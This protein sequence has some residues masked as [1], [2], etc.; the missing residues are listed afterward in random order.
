MSYYTLTKRIDEAAFTKELVAAGV[1]SFNIGDD[2]VYLTGSLTPQ[3]I[4]SRLATIAAVEA[5]HAPTTFTEA[6]LASAPHV[7]LLIS[8]I[9]A[10]GD[11]VVN[12]IEHP[13]LYPGTICVSHN[14][15]PEDRRA[16]VRAVA[17]A[18]DPAVFPALSVDTASTVVSPDG[19]ATDTVTVTD[20]R[21]AAASGKTVRL[22][23][24]ASVTVQV[25]SDA[26]VLDGAGQ[27]TATFGP[28]T[29]ITGEI[30]LEFYYVSGEADPVSFKVRFG[31]P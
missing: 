21:G 3:A 7:K 12:G 23:L 16:A 5:A 6:S 8:E 24:P 10:L 1:V 4:T 25:D 13:N 19:V 11:V 28:S 2:R 26:F 30:G 18:H 9:T 20:S 15:L 29:A 17:E 14:P 31:T 27:A 22:K